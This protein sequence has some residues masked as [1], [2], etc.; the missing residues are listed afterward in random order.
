MTYD[1]LY[2]LDGN[3]MFLNSKDN[4]HGNVSTTEVF[5]FINCQISGIY[6]EVILTDEY[7]FQ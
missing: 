6:L 5:A 1:I 2:P 3:L 4:V 7:K